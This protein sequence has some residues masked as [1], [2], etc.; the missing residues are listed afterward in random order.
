MASD[1]RDHRVSNEHGNEV[2]YTTQRVRGG[3]ELRCPSNM[4]QNE[5]EALIHT[6]KGDLVGQ[7]QVAPHPIGAAKVVQRGPDELGAPV[8]RV[9]PLLP[10]ARAWWWKGVKKINKSNQ[11]LCRPSPRTDG[12]RQQHPMHAP[13]QPAQ[14]S[15]NGGF[16]SNVPSTDMSM[17]TNLS[18]GVAS[19]KPRR[20]CA[21]S[22][23]FLKTKNGRKNVKS[24]RYRPILSAD[25]RRLRPAHAYPREN[26]AENGQN[27]GN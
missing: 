22:C 14:S 13:A 2:E 20:L 4:V 23:V 25:R 10:L 21:C 3:A 16:R 9:V 27:G 24:A 15:Q 11:H 7:C 12:R 5:V 8:A 19:M 18:S 17:M 26:P 1:C 6:G